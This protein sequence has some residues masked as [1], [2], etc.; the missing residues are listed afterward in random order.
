MTALWCWRTASSSQ[1]ISSAH[2]C[3]A[4]SPVLDGQ[5]RLVPDAAQL[6]RNCR[7]G[8]D[9]LGAHFWSSDCV[10]A[11]DA[12]PLRPLSSSP[13]V[14]PRTPMARQTLMSLSDYLFR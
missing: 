10:G 2:C 12:V 7:S 8:V 9:V 11:A 5:S 1:P 13:A 6:A 14:T 3:A 4:L